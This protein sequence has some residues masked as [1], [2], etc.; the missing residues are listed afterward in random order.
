ML[1]ATVL[2]ETKF[3]AKP[4]VIAVAGTASKAA[5]EA[6]DAWPA[7]TSYKLAYK[8]GSKL[9]TMKYCYFTMKDEID[10]KLTVGETIEFDEADYILEA[11]ETANGRT[12]DILKERSTIARV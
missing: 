7:T 11:K 1:F 6:Q 3:P 5:V 10:G 4:A 2:S 8:R 9:A 12:V